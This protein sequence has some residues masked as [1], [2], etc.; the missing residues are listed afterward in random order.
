MQRAEGVE[1][2]EVGAQIEEPAHRRPVVQRR[3]RPCRALI[4]AGR[5]E[6]RG[7]KAQ[8]GADQ[9][10]AAVHPRH[11]TSVLSRG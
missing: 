1:V 11:A 4:D 6:R 10:P 7:G 3:L 2:E 8:T 5:G 9:K